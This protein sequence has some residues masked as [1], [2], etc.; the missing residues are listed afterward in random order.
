MDIMLNQVIKLIVENHY[1]IFPLLTILSAA[2]ALLTWNQIQV[3]WRFY[4]SKR[5]LILQLSEKNF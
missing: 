1:I 4:F 3:G 5:R 2:L